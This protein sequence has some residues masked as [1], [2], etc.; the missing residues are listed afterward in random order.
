MKSLELTEAPGVTKVMAGG[1]MVKLEPTVLTTEK[2]YSKQYWS[3][4]ANVTNGDVSREPPAT[5]VSDNGEVFNGV[6]WVE[7]VGQPTL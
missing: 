2:T 4:G 1:A 5:G 3:P 6:A 7:N